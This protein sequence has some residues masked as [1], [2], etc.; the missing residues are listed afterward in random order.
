MKSL[1]NRDYQKVLAFMD[2]MAGPAQNFRH[3]A[4]AAFEKRFGFHQANFWICNERNDLI[5]PEMRNISHHAMD[6]YLDTCYQ[7]D[8]LMPNKIG[9]RLRNQH[10]LRIQDV[11]SPQEYEQSDYY[12]EFMS[13]HGYYHQMVAY[14]MDNGRLLGCIAFMRSEKENPFQPNDMACL[15][16]LT[17]FLSRSMGNEEFPEAFVSMSQ[18]ER[19]LTSKEREVLALVQK[20]YGNEVIARQLFVSINTV[21][22]H[23]QSI[24]RKFDVTNRTSLCYKIH[25]GQK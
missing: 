19:E 10:V 5:R 25:A 23:L 14:L 2:D 6:R 3:Q 18:E 12:D 13:R 1:S 9:H 22:K 15:E 17:R 16:L 21:K 24:Y 20:G 4:L 11:L 8:I 7:Y